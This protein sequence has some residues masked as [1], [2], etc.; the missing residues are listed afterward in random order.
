MEAISRERNAQLDTK[1]RTLTIIYRGVND[2]EES[3][4]V[5]GQLAARMRESRLAEVGEVGRET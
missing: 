3:E 5:L 2:L 1:G 4:R